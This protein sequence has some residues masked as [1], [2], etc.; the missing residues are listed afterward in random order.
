MKK[1]G[2]YNQACMLAALALTACTN[3]TQRHSFVERFM[4]I[5]DSSTI[6]CEVPVW[7]WEKNLDSGVCG[8]IDILQMRR[9]RLYVLD[10]K[11]AAGA[12]NET[13]VASQLYHYAS[14][15]SFRTSIPLKM[16]RCAWFDENAYYEFNPI[17]TKVKRTK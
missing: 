1:E 13:K 7:F 6:A 4:L 14:G 2:L 5:N 8:H 17:E 16:F 9:G 15:L 11:P 12:E 10:Y 3:K